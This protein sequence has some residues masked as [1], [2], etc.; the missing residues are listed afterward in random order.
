MTMLYTIR[1]GAC[2][3]SYGVY[4]AM[5]AEFPPSVIESAKRKAAELEDE[6]G[7]W[8]TAE[9]AGRYARIKAGMR[10]FGDL[11]ED[12]LG[13]GDV[14]GILAEIIQASS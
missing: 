4:V 14:R 10:V 1:D 11:A 9:G 6:S 12:R 5:A 8:G 7:Y 3:Q 13:S 2:T